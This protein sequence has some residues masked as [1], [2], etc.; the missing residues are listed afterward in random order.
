M[1]WILLILSLTISLF[2]FFCFFNS[3]NIHTRSLLKRIENYAENITNKKSKD[4]RSSTLKLF[5]EERGSLRILGMRIKSLEGLLIF[6]TILAL[7]GLI[8][9]ILFGFF[10]GNNFLLLAASIS[11]IMFFLP[12]EILKSKIKRDSKNI[13][14]EIPESL[15]ILSSLI[16]AGL[17][18]DQAINYY[19]NNYKGEISQLFKI[20]KIKLYEG[21]SR[22]NAYLGIAKLSF[23]NEFK[24]IIKII[25]QSDTIGN[26]INKVLKEL[27]K[28]I[29]ENQRDQIKIRAERLE[30]SLMLV[31]FIF[32][33]IPMMLLFL[34]PVIPQL[35]MIF[36]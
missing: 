18:L 22:K 35:K 32:M 8:I 36:N 13:L 3:R 27:S 1:N 21:K 9:F 26:P 14:N 17:N 23:C 12:S 29:R 4:G 15:D 6:R 24:T 34:L 11:L 28:T 31:I 16:K 19:S 25:V 30:S 2:I 10:I 7:N 20:A 5:L 33:F